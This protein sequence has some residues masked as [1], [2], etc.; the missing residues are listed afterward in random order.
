MKKERGITLI[1]LV[2]TIIV[3]LILAGVSISLTIG[4]NGVLNQATNAVGANRDAKVKEEVEMAWAGATADYWSDR[5]E[6]STITVDADFYAEKLNTYLADTKKEDVE[7]TYN[8]GD[9]TYTVEYVTKD[10]GMLYTFIMNG[11]GK[12]TLDSVV[13]QT[14]YLAD[15]V[16]IGDYIDI[17]LN[18]SNVIN[19]SGLVG[20]RVLSKSGNGRNGIVKLISAGCP[21]SV[22][23]LN[24]HGGETLVLL[25]NLY[26]ENL[27]ITDPG[28]SNPYFQ[29]NG[30]VIDDVQENN[31]QTVFGNCCYIDTTKGVHSFECE[32]L[33]GSI[34]TGNEL[35]LVYKELTSSEKTISELKDSSLTDST[36]GLAANSKACSLLANGDSYFLCGRSSD[37]FNNPFGVSNSGTVTTVYGTIYGVR[38]VVTL[39]LGIRIADNDSGDGSSASSAYK[40]NI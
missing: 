35:E 14:P 27:Q 30:F 4:N 20:W 5:A 36:L 26:V 6:D 40:I 28:G 3:L 2:I 29:S 7:V 13:K 25:K 31:M 9:E 15:V 18:Y 11:D 24:S 32:S 33:T 1:A 22:K 39:K 12:A 34:E 8:D 37:S 38:P 19:S 21:L 23:K 16:E 10:Q 17:E